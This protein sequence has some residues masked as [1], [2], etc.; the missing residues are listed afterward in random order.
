MS[1]RHW[2]TCREHEPSPAH[3]AQYLAAF[4]QGNVI[5]GSSLPVCV[6]VIAVFLHDDLAEAALEEFSLAVITTSRAK[7]WSTSAVSPEAV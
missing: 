1:R 7:I 4:E 2:K 5:V 6:A 3:H